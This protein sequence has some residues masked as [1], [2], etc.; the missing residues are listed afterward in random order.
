VEQE[1]E[2]AAAGEETRREV[3]PAPAPGDP[4]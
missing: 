3:S 2:S 1:Q 4:L